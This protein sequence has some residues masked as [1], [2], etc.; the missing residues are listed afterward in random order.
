MAT[1]KKSNESATRAIAKKEPIAANGFHAPAR[2]EVP[3]TY[4]L[5][6]NGKFPRTESGRFLA[7]NNPQGKLVANICYGS[8][9]DFRESVVAARNAFAKWSD[10]TA[11]NRSQILYRIGE[12]LEGRK[13]QFI[14]EQVQ[15]GTSRPAAEKDVNA[16][17]D[18]LIYY[19]GWA[20]KYQQVFSSVNPVSSSHFNFSMLE[21]TG[22]VTI[23]APNDGGLLGLVSVVAPVI[24]GGNTVVVLASEK[25]PLNAISF[26]EVLHTSDVPGGVINILTGKV[27]ELAGHFASHM[28][29]NAIVVARGDAA[30]V[31]KVKEQGVLNVKR[32]LLWNHADWTQSG[33]YNP[34]F[35]AD[36]QETKTTWHPVGI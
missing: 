12:V 20:D 15:L 33:A 34:Y 13:E 26:S 7:I 11:F 10:T 32:V 23:L 27:G 30:L 4:K 19:S 29:V 3:K 16:A 22:V 35:I 24:A 2:L 21:P 28:D 18:R 36:C 1:K 14:Q 9:K 5:Y 6:I 31:A 25:Q 8:R 17:I